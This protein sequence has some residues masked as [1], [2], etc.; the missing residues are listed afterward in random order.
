MS[1]TGR[2]LIGGLSSAGVATGL[3]VLAPWR[4]TGPTSH[5]EWRDVP[6][7]GSEY[8]SA[9]LS[10]LSKHSKIPH[11]TPRRVYNTRYF[12][13][14]ARRFQLPN[15][16]V[17]KKLSPLS[18]SELK[19]ELS[20]GSVDLRRRSVPDT[21]GSKCVALLDDPDSGFI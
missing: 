1:I 7:P 21:F 2:R 6:I 10:T 3:T 14:D 19:V 12:P 17:V 4:V 20:V 18:L 15:N 9:S 8:R 5:V 16:T 13:R 11:A